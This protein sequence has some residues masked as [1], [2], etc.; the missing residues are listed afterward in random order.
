MD[1]RRGCPGPCAGL[2][3]QG[4][5][6]ALGADAEPFHADAHRVSIVANRIGTVV[7]AVIE[8]DGRGF[9]PQAAGKDRFGLQGMRERTA[10]LGGQLRIESRS[11]AGTTLVV[12]VPLP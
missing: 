11:G 2:S 8:D 4:P 3:P 1:H 5:R 12:Q 10:L 6:P 7:T 9:D